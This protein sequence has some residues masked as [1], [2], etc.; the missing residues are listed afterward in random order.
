MMSSAAN[1][2][3]CWHAVTWLNNCLLPTMC[4]PCTEYSPKI[5]EWNSPFVGRSE[6]ITSVI[7]TLLIY[8][9]KEQ[10]NGYLT[11]L[12]NLMKSLFYSSFKNIRNKNIRN[13]SNSPLLCSW[14]LAGGLLIMS[15]ILENNTSVSI[16]QNLCSWFYCYLLV[17]FEML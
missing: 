6:R 16:G 2:S 5:D 9:N 4:Q 14:T 13:S 1:Q 3:F 15:H 11:S 10:R 17:I 8:Y 12:Y 7:T